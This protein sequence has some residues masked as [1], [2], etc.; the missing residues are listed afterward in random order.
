M[1]SNLTCLPE[2]IYQVHEFGGSFDDCYDEIV[3]TFYSEDAA[4]AEANRLNLQARNTSIMYNRCSHCPLLDHD[5]N[6]KLLEDLKSYCK[7]A[8]VET[9]AGYHICKNEITMFEPTSYKVVKVHIV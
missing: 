7:D 8:E 1:N 5:Y 4:T 9:V 6:E 2:Y 3:G